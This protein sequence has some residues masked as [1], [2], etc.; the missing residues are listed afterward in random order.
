M[1]DGSGQ[2][3]ESRDARDVGQFGLCFAQ[4]F[5]GMLAIRD[6]FHQFFVRRRKLAS[7]LDD[8]QFQLIARLPY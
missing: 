3:A 1:S 7:P 6:L 2:L 4:R 8:A 5:F